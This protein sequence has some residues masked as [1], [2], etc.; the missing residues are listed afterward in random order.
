MRRR[1]IRELRQ[2][3]AAC[4]T[5]ELIWQDGE[6]LC[7]T[8]DF[9]AQL[10]GRIPDWL[11]ANFTRQPPGLVTHTWVD[12]PNTKRALLVRRCARH[13]LGGLWA[14][15]GRRPPSSPEVRRAG[16]I[17]RLESCGIHAPRLLAF[18]QRPV[19]SWLIESFLLIEPPPGAVSLN[20]WLASRCTDL[21]PR[22]LI[23]EAA[24]L[25][26]RIHS[27]HCYLGGQPSFAVVQQNLQMAASVV[28]AKIDGLHSRRRPSK[29]EAW[30]DLIALRG[31]L[32]ST[33][34]RRTDELR[35]LLAYLG[36]RKCNGAVKRMARA[37]GKLQN[38]NCK[39]QIANLQ[40]AFCNLHFPRL[41][42]RT[43]SDLD[44]RAQGALP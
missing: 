4:S 35:L 43:P 24:G 34:S 8:P 13:P 1:R 9:R 16:L 19:S 27:L 41:E 7:L 11:V 31:E 32:S 25:L 22:Y 14:W 26:R 23:R 5:P 44:A 40:F 15:S 39:M 10:A 18:G 2:V 29:T 37:L 21:G 28:L 6:S 42:Q 20:E 17:F 38:A 30:K 12:I 3:P 36:L 33:A